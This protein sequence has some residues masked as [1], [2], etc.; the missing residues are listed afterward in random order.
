MKN[1]KN[2]ELPTFSFIIP[3][4]N[5]E[6]LIATCLDSLIELKSRPRDYEIILVDNGS[7][8]RTVEIAKKYRFINI[9]SL[10][11]GNVGAVRNFGAKHATGHFL[12]FLDA[13]CTLDSNWINRTKYL[14]SEDKNLI[15]G[16]GIKLPENANWVEKYWLL[17][18]RG[19]PPLPRQLIGASICL[20]KSNFEFIGGFSSE[21]TA[22]EDSDFHLRALKS[23]FSVQISEYFSVTHLGNAKSI[24]DFLK[25]QIWQGESYLINITS[26]LR[27]II[28]WLTTSYFFISTALIYS[29]LTSNA[30]I[31][32]LI[33]HQSIPILLTLKRNFRSGLEKHIV[34]RIFV[35]LILDNTYLIGRCIGMFYGPVKIK[36]KGRKMKKHPIKTKIKNAIK[37]STPKSLMI[38]MLPNSSRNRV[39][40]TFDDGPCPE[41]T[42]KVLEILNKKKCR[43]IFFVVGKKCEKHPDII[44][45]IIN[46]GHILANHSYSHINTDNSSFSKYKNDI[47]KC[48]KIL[49]N[50]N[51]NSKLFR[52]PFGRLNYKSIFVARLLKLKLIL[53]SN[54]GGELNENK[55]ESYDVIANCIIKNLK[56]N[57]IILMHDTSKSTPAALNL[58]L[59]HLIDEKIAYTYS[60]SMFD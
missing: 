22:G 34:T 4:F 1:K 3:A 50:I 45:K 44:R 10:E 51:A 53:M 7:T 27:D 56:N 59:N 28:F 13:D 36:L 31:P 20:T 2:S 19:S 25:R 43:A 17:E 23:G 40:I 14:L 38:R 30:F 39:L 60:E 24:C 52:P 47:Y 29:I 37:N 21:L 18:N 15:F 57:D 33:I 5:E 9:K 54:G 32:L 12:V 55:H 46:D 49:S 6:K 58:L 16:G 41:T 42:P 11:T 26:S 8:D 35:G 48:D